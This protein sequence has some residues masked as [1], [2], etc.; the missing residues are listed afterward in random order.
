MPTVDDLT[1]SLTIKD[2]SNLDKLRKNLDEILKTGPG[3]VTGG[4]GGGIKKQDL[5][6]IGKGLES[7]LN[8]IESYIED[9]LLPTS[10]RTKQE[11][12]T[13]TAGKID[14]M[15]EDFDLKDKFK[16]LFMG[17]TMPGIK[18][19]LKTYNKTEEE[20]PE[21]LEELFNQA[22]GI[23]HD[24]LKGA[25]PLGKAFK[26]VTLWQEAFSK[27]NS[28]DFKNAPD[29]MKGILTS[30]LDISDEAH[31]KMIKYYENVFGK[32]HVISKMN[33]A[34]LKESAYTSKDVSDK[35]KEELDLIEKENPMI[36]EILDGLDEVP[37]F[38]QLKKIYEELGVNI[39]KEVFSAGNIKITP[40][41]KALAFKWLELIIE[42]G[43]NPEGP[44]GSVLGGY[45]EFLNTYFKK[46]FG[47]KNIFANP[48]QID[49]VVTNFME[50]SE[51][52]GF[53]I[54]DKVIAGID[55]KKFASNLMKELYSYGPKIKDVV[56]I[57]ARG[58]KGA[59]PSN[60]PRIA[61]SQISPAELAEKIGED[62]ILP[63]NKIDDMVEAAKE[64]S[65]E[66]VDRKLEEIDNKIS[67]ISTMSEL[68]ILVDKISILLDK[69]IEAGLDIEGEY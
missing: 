46:E 56:H 49:A 29:R 7:Q 61:F 43:F 16:E 19:F 34:V 21:L 3:G 54:S 17:G 25:L 2:N 64:K 57:Q 45:G 31:N 36:K 37:G 58:I 69:A 8:S 28:P 20:L 4:G 68:R 15:I 32:E 44:P 40:E 24:A 33:L 30:I 13:I 48:E 63:P 62:I 52:I 51:E 1:V 22:R 27:L 41:L 38:P 50:H 47:N 55:F 10:L 59:F 26:A 53:A 6:R 23:L 9:Y 14:K 18:N 12:I 11:D 39:N 66:N 67:K 60:D 35:L 42:Q 65:T 5:E